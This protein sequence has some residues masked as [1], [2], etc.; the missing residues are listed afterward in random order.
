M[1]QCRYL[2]PFLYAMINI[3][4]VQITTKVEALLVSLFKWVYYTILLYHII[5]YICSNLR[6]N[7]SSCTCRPLLRLC[8]ST[9]Q[10]REYD[11]GEGRVEK[12]YSAAASV[13]R[14]WP[15]V[16]A[17]HKGERNDIDCTYCLLT[18]QPPKT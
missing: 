8:S 15:W 9:Q 3:S 1:Y 18:S 12:R 6:Q 2:D 14:I 5:S 10:P 13:L 4:L 17:A 16:M 11:S 7:K